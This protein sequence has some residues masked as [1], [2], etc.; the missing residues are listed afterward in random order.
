[1]PFYVD[2]SWIYFCVVFGIALICSL[3]MSL[4]S[5]NFYTMHVVIR[6][7][8]MLDLEFPAS[9]QELATFIK[10]IFKLPVE[11]SKKSLWALKTQLYFH[12]LF[13]PFAYG[14]IF[15]ACMKVSFKMTYFGHGLFAML[16]WIQIIPLLCDVVESIYLLKKIKPDP[17]ISNPAVHQAYV[18]LE[19]LKWGIPLT[20]AICCFGA[21]FYFWLI[22]MYS[23]NSLHF[24]L[25]ATAEIIIFF[26]LKKLTKKSE[27]EMMENIL[28]AAA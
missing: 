18:L 24:L 20:A 11:I 4:L 10:G 7:F 28:V 2:I 22:G 17:V 19:I 9:P 12:F 3:I 26:I 15:I 21:A 25:I 6:K 5:T 27:K 23:F 14:S 13:I 8:S 1:M 16:A